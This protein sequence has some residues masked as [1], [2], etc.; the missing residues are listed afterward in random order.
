MLHALCLFAGIAGIELGLSLV[1]NV[2]PVCFVEQDK[3]CQDIL[4]RRHPDAWIWD[5]VNTFPAEDWAGI[6]LLTAGFPCQ[7]WSYAGSRAGTADARWLWARIVEVIRLSRPRIVCLENVPGLLAGGLGHVLADLAALGFA[8]EWGVFS[9]ADLEAPQRRERVFVLAVGNAE[10]LQR[11]QG[12]ESEGELLGGLGGSGSHVGHLSG[13]R[14]EERTL[15]EGTDELPPAIGNGSG[16]EIWPLRF[17]DCWHDVP[18]KLLP[19]ECQFQRKSHGLPIR[20]ER[21]LRRAR[22]KAL[23]NSVSPPVVAAAWLEL[24]RRLGL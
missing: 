7:P 16:M 21:S 10:G 11:G 9:C 18:E 24:G 4:R 6:D 13:P 14:L 8:A 12:R 17:D 15:P 23:G 19:V 2:V 3:F 1:A 20:M 22:L 5:D